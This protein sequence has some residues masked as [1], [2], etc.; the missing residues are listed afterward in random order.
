MPLDNFYKQHGAGLYAR[1][2]KCC[3]K[4]SKANYVANKKHYLL[5]ARKWKQ[6]VAGKECAHKNYIQR[7]KRGLVQ[8]CHE[9]YIVNNKE[10]VREAKRKYKK[11]AKG[12]AA[13]RR[14]E[15]KRRSKEWKIPNR[16]TAEDWQC[17]LVAYNFRCAYCGSRDRLSQDHYMP[18]A[19]GGTH[20]KDNV[21]PACLPCNHKKNAKHPHKL[22]K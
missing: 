22:F 4:R 8:A 7:K 21:I 17:I 16:L 11:S 12:K 2:K 3:N 20:T 14:E 9:R 13:R 1:C 5:L 19:L 18:L 10:K 15:A 6:T